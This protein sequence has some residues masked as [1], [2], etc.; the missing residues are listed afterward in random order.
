MAR[1]SDLRD[2]F[3]DNSLSASVWNLPA[4]GGAQVA[5]TN[6]ELRITGTTASGYYG[7]D[8]TLTYDFTGDRV[9]VQFVGYLNAIVTSFEMY[10]LVNVDDTGNNQLSWMYSPNFGFFRCFSKVGGVTSQ[11]GSDLISTSATLFRARYFAIRETGGTTYWEYSIDAEHWIVHASIANTLSFGSDKAGLME[12]TWQ[13]EAT[14]M[15]ARFDNFNIKPIRQRK[16]R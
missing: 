12:G 14:T 16:F 13:A 1:F 7:I 10:M 3:D 9:F 5:E 2:N 8:T 11:V 4:W 6:K 15:I